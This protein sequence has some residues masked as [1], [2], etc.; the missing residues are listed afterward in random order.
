V[1]VLASTVTLLVAS[2]VVGAY[3]ERQH[4]AQAVQ[5]AN[6]QAQILADTVTAA[7]VFGDRAALQ[8]YV[9]ALKANS[10]VDA[11]GVFDAR[12]RLLAGYTHSHL[13]DR[14]SN[15]LTPATAPG[16]IIVKVPVRQ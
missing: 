3:N 9:N 2:I 15:A 5:A 10:D 7:L 12:G 6:V 1:F 13:A 14:L 16:R 11:V 8:E 4:V